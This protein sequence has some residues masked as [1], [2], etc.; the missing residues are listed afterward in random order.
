MSESNAKKRPRR[1]FS[2][3]DKATI[4]RRHL[5]DRVP[6]S[7]LCDEYK[8]QPTL[9]Y[10]WQRQAFE[11]LGAALQDGRTVRGQQ[12]TAAGDRA[13]VE[14]LEAKL[15][16]KDAFIAS[17]HLALKKRL[18][19]AEA[20]MGAARYARYRRRLRSLV[21][22]MHGALAE[23]GARAPLDRADAILSSH[24]P[25]EPGNSDSFVW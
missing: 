10:L 7:H 22:R 19:R 12:R 24:I 9:F 18:G 2:P 8:I 3:E 1:R 20:A 21:Q 6:V 16:K 25:A 23:L 4:L 5:V 11:H 14:A 13:R 17:E 15:A